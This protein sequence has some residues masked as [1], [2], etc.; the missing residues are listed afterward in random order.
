MQPIHRNLPMS[1][2]QRS[3]LRPVVMYMAIVWTAQAMDVREALAEQVKQARVQP[4]APLVL[5]RQEAQRRRE[6]QMQ[7]R[8]RQL[9]AVGVNEEMKE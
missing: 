9:S 2:A 4:H 5:L 7:V 1:S 6:R 8:G 3:R